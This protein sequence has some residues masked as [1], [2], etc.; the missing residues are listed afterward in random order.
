MQRLLWI[1]MR[2]LLMSKDGHGTSEHV[3]SISLAPMARRAV[4][5]AP[6][7]WPLELLRRLPPMKR[8]STP[9][10]FFS[11]GSAAIAGSEMTKLAG[12]TAGT[13]SLRSSRS[14]LA[15]VSTTVGRS[16][17][18]GGAKAG[19]TTCG[20]A[21]SETAHERSP[22]RL[23]RLER[24]VLLAAEAQ[25]SSAAQTPHLAT[26]MPEPAAGAGAEA[27]KAR[28]EWAA[29]APC[30][31]GVAPGTNAPRPGWRASESKPTHASAAAAAE[32]RKPARAMTAAVPSRLRCE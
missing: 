19:V 25:M 14:P 8:A 28:A 15:R 21:F 6:R 18:A 4:R 23:G 12:A 13:E 7:D 22:V 1:F 3:G 27:R 17:S 31:A 32:I 30:T 9:R 10:R 29:T 16:S 5:S 20:A 26:S 24:R 11:E 2:I